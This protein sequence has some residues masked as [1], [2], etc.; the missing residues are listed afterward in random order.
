MFSNQRKMNQSRKCTYFTEIFSNDIKPQKISSHFQCTLNV[1]FNVHHQDRQDGNHRDQS[2]RG[3]LFACVIFLVWSMHHIDPI[4]TQV[5]MEHGL[6]Q[7]RSCGQAAT[8]NRTHFYGCHSAFLGGAYSN[9]SSI[10]SH[11]FEP[12]FCSSILFKK[13]GM[14]PMNGKHSQLFSNAIIKNYWT[15][16]FKRLH[17]EDKSGKYPSLYSVSK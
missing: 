10:K 1:L 15:S 17:E 16:S 2:G 5:G 14:I 7:E 12:I 9:G 13:F 11:N 6:S 4:I 3:L 8:W